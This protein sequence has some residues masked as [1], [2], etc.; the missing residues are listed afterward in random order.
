MDVNAAIKQNFVYT[1]RY[2]EIGLSTD[3]IER[4]LL[5]TLHVLLRD[6]Y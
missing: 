6:V 4:S 2:S 5:F 3:F 1:E